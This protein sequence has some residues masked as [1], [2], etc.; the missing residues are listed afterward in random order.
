[1]IDRNLKITISFFYY[2]FWKLFLLARR[3]L[4]GK[5]WETLV[6]LTYHSVYEDERKNF[7]RQ[8]ESVKKTVHAVFPDGRGRKE[9]TPHHIAVTFDDGYLNVIKN[10]V[11]IL[12]ELD[13]PA[14][15]FVTTGKLGQ[16]PDWIIG[17]NNK[18][19]HEKIATAQELLEL[20]GNRYILGSHTV[21]H[22]NLAEMD[23]TSIRRELADS[24][25]D[26]EELLGN[27]VS[28]LA[29]PFGAYNQKVLTIAREEGYKKVF[30]NIPDSKSQ[31]WDPGGSGLFLRGRVPVSPLDG[32]LEFRLKCSGAY[33]W[34]PYA[35]TAKS[36]V[37]K[38]IDMFRTVARRP[39]KIQL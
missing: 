38:M 26:L 2:I 9:N 37:K 17:R 24:K 31:R 11:P 16:Q 4:K 30:A 7:R 28:L 29:F 3:V 1:M 25:R 34:L 18:D 27:E 19:R 32:M 12:Q 21:N 33:Q 5:S 36:K 10:A 14:T 35:I 23:E 39:G 8:M 6:I 15:I 13:I 22:G 20:D